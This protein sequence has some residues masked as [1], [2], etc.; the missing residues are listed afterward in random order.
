VG[1]QNVTLQLDTL[2]ETDIYI[3]PELGDISTS[4]FNRAADTIGLGADA[5]RTEGAK[6]AKL[7]IT[8]PAIVTTW[9]PVAD[10]SGR[11]R[12]SASSA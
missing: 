10:G 6:L 3:H 11:H 7:A 8:R 12:S 5:A 4:D 9:L 1:Q 2:R